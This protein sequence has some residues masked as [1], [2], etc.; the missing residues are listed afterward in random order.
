MSVKE[1]YL[2]KGAARQTKNRLIALLYVA[3][4]I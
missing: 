2:Y 1:T 4:K 3:K